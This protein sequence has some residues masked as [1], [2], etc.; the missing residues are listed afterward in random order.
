MDK[1]AKIEIEATPEMISALANA[2]YA[3]FDDLSRRRGSLVRGDPARNE[4][5]YLDGS[6]HLRRVAGRVLRSLVEQESEGGA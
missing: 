4:K 6:F 3:A 1:T 5:T 2:M